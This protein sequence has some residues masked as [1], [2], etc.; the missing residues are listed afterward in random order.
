MLFRSIT[1][2]HYKTVTGVSDNRRWH[3][4]IVALADKKPR[5]LTSDPRYHDLNLAF[6][7]KGDEIAFASNRTAD[8]DKQIDLNIYVV[9]VSDGS[10][11]QVTRSPI[12]EYAPRWSPP[13]LW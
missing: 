5:A 4:Y 6:S 1:R 7:P 2:Y 3:I 12:S 10:I 11:R 8:P 9:R 13:A